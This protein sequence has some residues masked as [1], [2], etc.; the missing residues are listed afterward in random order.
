MSETTYH[1]VVMR[2]DES[3]LADVPQLAGVHTFARTLPGLDREI[4]E[5][6]AL[7]EDLPE[8]AE[9]G[10]SL[11]Y[12]VHTG[13]T[14][15][16]GAAADLRIDRRRLAEQE[17]DLAA[18]TAELVILLRDRRMPVRDVA[19]LLGIS[20]QRVSQIAQEEH[21]KRSAA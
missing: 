14:E 5:A 11:S 18:R 20:A 15:L 19:A 7:A 13:D 12:E 2:E 1:V 4:R 16:D 17:R 21:G 10:L 3:W 8:G 6:I 9:P